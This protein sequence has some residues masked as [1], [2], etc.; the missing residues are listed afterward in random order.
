VNKQLTVSDGKVKCEL[1]IEVVRDQ[2]SGL[3]F[4]PV[5]ITYDGKSHSAKVSGNL[6]SSAIVSYPNGNEFIN[7]GTYEVLAIVSCKDYLTMQLKTTLTIQK[8]NYD[9]SSII[10]SSKE[11][12]VYDGSEKS[13]SISGTLPSGVSVSYN[14]KEDNES[15]T[16]HSG[17]VAINAGKYI[18][19]AH[20]SS[21]SL[22]YNLIDDKIA[23][24]FIKKA[25]YDLTTISFV[26]KTYT[27]D[28]SAKSIEIAGQLPSGVSVS[29]SIN[30][31][32]TNSKI[33]AGKYTVIAKFSG[34]KNHNAIESK[35]AILTIQKANYDMSN[36]YFDSAIFVYDGTEKSIMIS[37]TLAQGVSVKYYIN[38]NETNSMTDVGV[39]EVT[40]KFSIVDNENYNQIEDKVA[41]LIIITSNGEA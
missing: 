29:Y 8:A 14:I 4:D 13:I 41:K 11:N 21:N 1:K 26:D 35:S 32:N 40:A 6:P 27:Y 34:D 7:A 36:I 3:I 12:E 15:S 17:N 23:T 20:F 16:I 5:S 30:G 2:F 22:N 19:T 37:G 10:F 9:M 33:Y 25:D 18:L 39:Y 24:L 38:G 28:N 31:E